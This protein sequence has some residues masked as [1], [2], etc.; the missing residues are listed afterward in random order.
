[1]KVKIVNNSDNPLPEYSTS[2]SAGMDLF[3]NNDKPI[4]IKKGQVVLIPTGIHIE[5][6]KGYEAQIRARS[7]LALNHGICIPNGLGTIDSDYRGEIGMILTNVTDVPYTV[8]KGM[9]IA[10][11]VIAKHETVEFEEVEVLS[12]SDRGE[13]GFGHTGV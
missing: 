2:G 4:K 13:G 10:Q 3:A 5:L 6:P 8:N 12:E 1:M 7:G 9:R 11:M